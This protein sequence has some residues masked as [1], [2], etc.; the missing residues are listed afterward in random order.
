MKANLTFGVAGVDPNLFSVVCVLIVAVTSGT[1]TNSTLAQPCAPAWS[2][3][4]DPAGPDR[5]VRSL[6]THKGALYA[7]GDWSMVA[8]APANN[9][10][11]FDGTNWSGAIAATWPYSGSPAGNTG[12]LSYQGSLYA[13]LGGTTAFPS[14]YTIGTIWNGTEWVPWPTNGLW[15]NPN[16]QVNINRGWRASVH[17]N[18]VFAAGTFFHINAAGTGGDRRLLAEFDGTTWSRMGGGYGPDT[19]A[20]DRIESLVSYNG[21]LYVAGLFTQIR[22]GEQGLGTT[23]PSANIARYNGGGWEALPNG[24][25][26]GRVYA[27]AVYSNDLYVGGDFT[28]TADSSISLLRIARLH[29]GAWLPVGGGLTLARP[30]SMAVADDGRSRALFIGATSGEANNTAPPADTVPVSGV[31]RWNGVRYSA[32]AEGITGGT[33]VYA[34]APY[35]PGT[36]EALFVGADSLRNP[37]NMSFFGRTARWGPVPM[38]ERVDLAALEVIQVVQ[39]WENS[40]PL[41]QDKPTLVRAHLQLSDA[42]TNHIVVSG[43]RLHGRRGGAALPDSPLTPM[44]PAGRVTVKTNYAA[45]VRTNL[46]ESLNF[47]LPVAWL[48]GNVELRLEWTNGVLLCLCREP[49]ETGGVVSNCLVRV[50]FQEMPVPEVKFVNVSWSTNVNSTNRLSAG[51][52]PELHSRLLAIYPIAQLRARGGQLYWTNMAPTNLTGLNAQLAIMRLFDQFLQVFGADSNVARRLYYGAVPDT[53]LPV[54]SGGLADDIPGHVSSGYVPDDP[55]VY[56]RNRHAH[57]IGHTLARHHAVNQGIFGTNAGGLKRGACRERADAAAPEFPIY[58]NF[59]TLG[60]L[61]VSDAKDVY[62]YDHHQRRLVN[63]FDTLDLMSYCA[64]RTGWRWISKYTYTNIQ[65]ALINR[66]GAGGAPPPAALMVVAPQDYLIVR[67]IIELATSQTDF[68]PFLTVRLQDPP[69]PPEP[70]DFILRLL[71]A[72]GGVIMDI[73][74]QPEIGE[75]D[76]AEAGLEVADATHGSFTITVP[77]DPRISQAVVLHGAQ[78][79]ASRIASANPP[80]VRILFPNGGQSF[81]AG[82]ITISWTAEDLDN[83]TLYYIVQYSSDDGRSWTTLAVDWTATSLTVDSEML[84]AGFEARIRVI[85]TDGFHTALDVSDG[86]FSVQNHSPTVAIQVPAADELFIADQQIV[87]EANAHDLEDGLLNGANVQW[88]SSRDGFLGLGAMLLH[89]AGELSEGEHQISVS[90]TDNAG[91]SANATL[92]IV[93]LREPQPALQILFTNNQIIL[94]WPAPSS[95]YVL[96]V[97]D[98]LSA[99]VWNPVT[100]SPSLEDQRWTLAL[101]VMPKAQFYRLVRR[102][103]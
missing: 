14:N 18:R 62:G 87:F 82:P 8:G 49:A 42:N 17:Q 21:A 77:D 54:Y 26:N 64:G 95:G 6:T 60:P 16:V 9:V 93:V 33:A 48:S 50:N 24:G 69:L 75:A 70:G 102:F 15:H 73:P 88:H 46:N 31:V 79:K 103:E 56:G 55:L 19:L 32:M 44:N 36:G 27:M 35:D 85:A 5:H 72:T 71:D 86:L 51:V 37:D 92:S 84:P 30:R 68:L 34:M 89:E 90:A 41:I 3:Y 83:D 101:D 96:Q 98:S 99:S 28:A 74:F 94:S 2:Y 11:V 91:L 12:L 53:I 61:G 52:L 23:T 39:D 43:V 97:A 76:A 67:G 78:A 7:R 81:G 80:S 100:Q 57:E 25:L 58:L 10:A 13:P 1:L 40:V 20:S 38:V 29:N 47:M 59:P 65:N 66:F 22:H 63:P 45:G 4:L